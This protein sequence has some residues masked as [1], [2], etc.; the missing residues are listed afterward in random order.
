MRH[1]IAII[2]ALV[3]VVAAGCGSDDGSD[4]S[5]TTSSTAESTSS[6][7]K[8]TTTEA[9]TTTA[10]DDTDVEDVTTGE[11]PRAE[12]LAA[13]YECTELVPYEAQPGEEAMGVEIVS[14]FQCTKDGNT[15]D[16]GDFVTPEKA[17]SAIDV[18]AGFACGLE[19]I[20]L[21]TV[22]VGS[23][24]IGAADEAADRSL[25]QVADAVGAEV[26]I[27]TCD[28]VEVPSAWDDGSGTDSVGG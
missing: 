21:Q 17:R 6:T 23:W 15:Y 28:E 26:D 13:G 14:E 20:P 19:D 3:L 8:S 4:A 12:L 1:P 24:V 2:A 7:S 27:T 22:F 9:T 25:D 16:V 5:D 11:G 10:E 18:I